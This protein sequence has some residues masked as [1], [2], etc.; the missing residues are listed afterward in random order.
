MTMNKIFTSKQKTVLAVAITTILSA[1]SAYAYD[2]HDDSDLFAERQIE[3]Y[4]QKGIRAGSFML[5]PKFENTNEYN[6]NIYYRD[7]NVAPGQKSGVVSSYVAHFRPGVDIRSDW[8][9][10]AFNL[11]FDSDI[12]EYAR[13]TDQNNY[14]DLKTNMDGRLDITRDANLSGG[15]GYNSLHEQRGSPDQVN[16]VGPT[17]Y[18]TKVMRGFYNQ[19]FNRVSLK[20][21]LDSSRFDYE[22]VQSS[23]GSVL[24]MTSRNHWE[25]APSMRVG[26]EI[27]PEY[28]A[29]VK[30]VYKQMDYD[31]LVYANGVYD[32]LD[33]SKGAYNRNSTGYNALGGLAFDLTDLI[34]GDM[35]VGY[36]ERN[37]QDGRL[38][39]ISGINGFL[40]LKWRPTALTTVTSR[41]SRDIN[42]TTQNG[43]SGVYA[44]GIALGVEHELKRNIL[45]K[46][47][48]NYSYNDY[49]GYDPNASSIYA[50]NRTDN[51]YGGLASAKYLLNRNLSAD[52]S[53]AYQTRDTNYVY[54]NYDVHQVMLNLK[55]QF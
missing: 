45:L 54:S 22:N 50:M 6:S 19:K 47:S 9:R 44:T 8:N 27:Q 4:A 16:G 52:L 30:F 38:Q 24:Q 14:Q 48:G 55:G 11:N 12:T 53:Y 33:P 3:A 18:D 13:Y 43:V 26:Y 20:A 15:F 35:S 37:Y 40:N 1:S 5:L 42:E 36:L 25:Y 31:G 49:K 23:T 28:E 17:F 46:L 7:T 2:S 34:T 32:P 41:I 51:V 10:H 29:F 39:S 21:G